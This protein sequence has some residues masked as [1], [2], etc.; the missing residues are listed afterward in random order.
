MKYFRILSILI[1]A[2]M[3]KNRYTSYF[4]NIFY[5]SDTSARAY[6]TWR[7][8]ALRLCWKQARTQGGVHPLHPPHQT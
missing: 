6:K 2:S 3:T 8:A 4:K 7:M 5:N 1:S